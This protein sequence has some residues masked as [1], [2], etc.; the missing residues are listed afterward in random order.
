MFRCPS[1]ASSLHRLRINDEHKN[2]GAKYG[3]PV[4]EPFAAVVNEASRCGCPVAAS[5]RVGAT[6]DLIALVNPDFVF[7]C[8][9]V[10]TPTELLL[11]ALSDPTRLARRGQGAL[12][13]MQS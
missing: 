11:R 10:P 12:R 2:E 6:T 8:G 9:D 1:S 5:D 13:R 3:G 7:S 4:F